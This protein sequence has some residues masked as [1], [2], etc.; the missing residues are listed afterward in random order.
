L[1]FLPE[2]A[3]VEYGLEPNMDDK[4]DVKKDLWFGRVWEL[5]ALLGARYR[6]SRKWQPE[7]S[8]ER[9]KIITASFN[10]VESLAL[11]AKVQKQWMK[12]AVKQSKSLG[13]LGRMRYAHVRGTLI[14]AH[15]SGGC[16]WDNMRICRMIARMGFLVIAPDDFAYPE[17]TAMG[18]MRHKDLIPLHRA[19]DDVDYWAD[20][21]IYCS[22]AKGTHTYS[23]KADK[24]LSDPKAACDLYEKCYQLR[25]NE[26]HHLIKHLPKWIMIQGFFLGGTSEGAMTI[27]RFDDQRYGESVLGRFINSFSV[28]YCYFTPKPEAGQIG[29]QLTVPTLNIIG[30]KDQF[31]G[32]EDSV[33]KVVAQNGVTG[34]GEKNPTGNGYKTFVKQG[35]RVA[36]VCVMEN[37]VHSPCNTHDNFLRE[38][39]E[40]FFTRPD[41]IWKLD[42]V[43]AIAPTMSRLIEVKE[44]TAEKKVGEHVSKCTKVFVPKM[45]F[46][47]KMSLRRAQALR[48]VAHQSKKFQIE[49]AAMQAEED[50]KNKE[51]MA[52]AN[53][54]LDGL[55]GHAKVTV[56][57]DNYYA[58]GD[59]KKTAKAQVKT[60]AR[61]K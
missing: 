45:L 19:T 26:L 20:D 52:E 8:P 5:R 48:Q 37:G 18:Q 46:P 9:K 41:S 31:F 33:T 22:D 36:L 11:L 4:G 44:R 43:W 35:M 57:D 15:G 61:T 28:E 34:Y 13:I 14:Y 51:Y 10:S 2:T 56:K 21:L 59:H 25:R 29:G 30:T 3:V 17:Y 55:R 24:V 1:L 60:A 38:L 50:E 54:M 53:K 40:T 42:K 39:F 16:S 32:P 49:L 23:T 7:L 27:A 6:T 47:Q 58:Q 12:A